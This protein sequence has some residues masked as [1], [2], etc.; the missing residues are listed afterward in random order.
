MMCDIF[1]RWAVVDTLV[2]K[3]LPTKACFIHLIIV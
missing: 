3:C 1:A 2:V